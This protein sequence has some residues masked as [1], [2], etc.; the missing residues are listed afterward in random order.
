[1]N[2]LQL[3]KI[4]TKTGK[5]SLNENKQQNNVEI[6]EEK[7]ATKQE[8][9]ANNEELL[10]EVIKTEDNVSDKSTDVSAPSGE[11]VL[12]LSTTADSWVEVQDANNY[13]LFFELIKKD[14]TQQ[15]KGK[16]PFRMFLGNAPAVEVQLNNQSVDISE[17]VRGNNIAHVAIY[18]DGSV[19]NVRR[20]K[21]KTKDENE[22]QSSTDALESSV[23]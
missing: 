12:V 11:D 22:D 2:T 6:K 13:R 17:H 3:A 5:P 21:Q 15:L 8:Q 4:N 20:Q 1:M 23:N 18:K 19:A 10:I 16:A 9:E 7:E 14:K